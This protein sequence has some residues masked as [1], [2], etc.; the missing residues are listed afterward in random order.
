MPSSF[1]APPF[2]KTWSGSVTLAP[3]LKKPNRGRSFCTN[4]GSMVCHSV[5]HCCAWIRNVH[6]YHSLVWRSHKTGKKQTA[7]TVRSAEEK[8]LEPPC[9]LSRIRTPQ[10]PGG[11]RGTSLKIP[12]TPDT[13]FFHSSPLIGAIQHT[14]DQFTSPYPPQPLRYY[15]IYDTHITCIEDTHP[16]HFISIHDARSCVALPHWALCTVSVLYIVCILYVLVLSVYNYVH[17]Y[18]V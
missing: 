7:R 13:T 12:C 17:Q 8:L 9:P 5:L 1:W 11:R 10:E 18:T 15:D 16:S 14:V 3:S 2:L 6:N 4:W